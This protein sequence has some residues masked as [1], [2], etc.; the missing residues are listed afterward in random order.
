LHIMNK[1]DLI[2]MQPR[3]DRDAAG[4]PVRVWLSAATGLGL[5]LLRQALGELLGGDRVQ[6]AL[7]LPLTA[8][9]L[10]ARL[11]AAGAIS[12]ETVDEHGWQLQIDAPRSVIAP[13]SGADASETQLLR[14]LLTVAECPPPQAYEGMRPLLE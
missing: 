8:G 5:D 4:K 1:I 6:S 2:D 7:T 11:K 3:I 9:R 12:K 13:L 10:H 14:D